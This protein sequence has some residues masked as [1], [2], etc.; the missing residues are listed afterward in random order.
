MGEGVD[1]SIGHSILEKL[2]DVRGGSLRYEVML[3]A[4]LA[5]EPVAQH[6]DETHRWL[7]F[8]HQGFP[9]K[10]HRP[11]AETIC[12]DGARPKI[13]G[14][15]Q[16]LDPCWA[17]RDPPIVVRCFVEGKDFFN[18]AGD[19]GAVLDEDDRF[20]CHHLHPTSVRKLSSTDP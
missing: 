19:L 2:T 12:E 14:H 6:V 8:R 20:S 1:E 17:R 4:P 10:L 7:V 9:A 16:D 18:R 13:Q 3:V 5:E 11:A 15:P